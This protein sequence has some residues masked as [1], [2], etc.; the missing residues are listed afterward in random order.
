MTPIIPKNSWW[1][2]KNEVNTIARFMDPKV[3]VT[4]KKSWI[5]KI[6]SLK[7]SATALGNT[8]YAPLNWTEA[9]T[10]NVLPHEILGHVKQF[11]KYTWPGMI[12]IYGLLFFPIYF[13]WGRYKMELDANVEQWRYMLKDYEHGYAINRA[14]LT[15][16][17]LENA[18]KAADTL[19]SS[20]YLFAVP[21]FYARAGYKKAAL[22]LISEFVVLDK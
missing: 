18:Q 19:A 20:F 1:H 21:K 14:F 3:T 13:A 9:A 6:G 22:N 10:L 16:W 5:W 4:Y 11:R 2:S 12:F 7:N 8:V 15:D 17:L